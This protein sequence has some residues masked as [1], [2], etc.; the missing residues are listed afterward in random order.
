M[1]C[2]LMAKP[3]IV[4]VGPTGVG[5]TTL[6]VRLAQS[7]SGEIVSADSRQVYRHMDI[8]TAKPTLDEKRLAPH[9]LVDILD[10]DQSLTLADYQAQA[11]AAIDTVL[12]SE[13]LPLL[14]GGT[15]QYIHAVVEGWGIPRVPPHPVLRAELESIADVYG[16]TVLHYRLSQVD[17]SAAQA[18]DRRNVRRV[19]RA[20]EV[21][22]VSGVPISTHQTRK[23]PPYRLLQIGLTRPRP[24]LYVRIDAR[25]DHMIESGLVDEVKKLV[26]MGYGW[27]LPS[28]SSLGYPQIGTYLRGESTLADSIA[29]IKRDTRAFIRRQYNWFC[30]SDP[31][32]HWFDVEET[33]FTDILTFVA[34]WLKT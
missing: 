25:I 17:P 22:L 29:A 32:I 14:V 3:L 31:A 13:K 12:A 26:E 16:P 6:A 18:R 15:G 10:P 34:N 23:P 21:Y 7:L 20:L 24:A 5:K 28:T 2:G 1:Q 11:Y 30:L 33:P 9:H 27:E 8:G 4:V 19:V